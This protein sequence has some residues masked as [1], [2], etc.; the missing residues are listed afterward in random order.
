MRDFS[1]RG[2]LTLIWT[3]ELIQ[4]VFAAVATRKTIFVLLSCGFVPIGN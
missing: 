2:N 1:F 3:A 4:R